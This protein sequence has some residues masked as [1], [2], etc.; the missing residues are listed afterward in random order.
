M[1]HATTAVHSK[2]SMSVKKERLLVTAYRCCK[3]DHLWLPR[4]P[5][6]PIDSDALP[7][8]CPSREC[9]SPN[10]NR[11][12]TNEPGTRGPAKASR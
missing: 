8:R 10:W 1:T 2:A 6:D 9:A 3:C 12:E 7:K 5:F 11:P 4:R